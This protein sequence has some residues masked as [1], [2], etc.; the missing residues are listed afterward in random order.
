MWLFYWAVEMI[1][2]MIM[3]GQFIV[4]LRSFKIVVSNKISEVQYL[5][6]SFVNSSVKIIIINSIKKQSLTS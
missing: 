2:G 3:F 5:K 6:K 4:S 1:K